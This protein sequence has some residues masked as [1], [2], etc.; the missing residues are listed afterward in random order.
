M[1]YVHAF[2]SSGDDPY[3][4]TLAVSS[5]QSTERFRA[6][7]EECLETARTSDEYTLTDVVDGMRSRGYRIKIINPTVTVEI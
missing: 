1:Y 7:W 5:N 2:E 4:Y 3:P 6:D